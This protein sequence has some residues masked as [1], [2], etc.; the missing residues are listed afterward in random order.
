MAENENMVAELAALRKQLEA[1]KQKQEE[2]PSPPVDH[3]ATS[4][5]ETE[6]AVGADESQENSLRERLDELF[7]LLEEE[8]KKR[9]A[10]SALLVFSLGIVFG[11]YLK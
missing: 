3:A 6:S 2:G 7:D 1:L 11:R 10:V 8:A 4:P 9:P 5:A